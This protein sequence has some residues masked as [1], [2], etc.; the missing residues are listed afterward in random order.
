VVAGNTVFV[1]H[2]ELG[3]LAFDVGTG[4]LAAQ[5]RTGSGIAGVPTYDA[6]LQRLFAM[7][8]RGMFLALRVGEALAPDGDSTLAVR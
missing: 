2:S 4:E 1:T 8:N 6:G 7:S 3:L 5:L